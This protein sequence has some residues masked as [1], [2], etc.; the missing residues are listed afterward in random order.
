MA[1][2]NPVRHAFG[3]QYIEDSDTGIVFAIQYLQPHTVVIVPIDRETFDAIYA[4]WVC[5]ASFVA[6][7]TEHNMS[8]QSLGWMLVMQANDQ[9][10]QYDVRYGNG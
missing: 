3:R 8:A 1:I 4:V 10:D 9:L 5:G 2:A 7:A 6:L